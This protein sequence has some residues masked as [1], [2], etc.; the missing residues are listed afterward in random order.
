MGITTTFVDIDD[1]DAVNAAVQLRTKVEKGSSVRCFGHGSL[2]LEASDFGGHPLSVCE[3]RCYMLRHCPTPRCVWWTCPA[4]WRSHMHGCVCNVRLTWLLQGESLQ[5]RCECCSPNLSQVY[6]AMQGLTCIVDNTFASLTVSPAGWGVDVVVQSL[7]KYTSGSGDIVA[8]VED[9]LMCSLHTPPLARRWAAGWVGFRCL[10]GLV[11]HHAG[12]VCSSKAFI[13]RMM[14]LHESPCMML[15]RCEDANLSNTALVQCCTRM[16]CARGSC[17]AA[18]VRLRRACTQHC[19]PCCIAQGPTMDPRTASELSLRLPHLG[20]RVAE[21]SR[22][23]LAV[24]ERLQQVEAPCG[25]HVATWH[26][27]LAE[28]RCGNQG[29]AR[30]FASSAHELLACVEPPGGRQGTVPWSQITSS[31]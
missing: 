21:H 6:I 22:R 12:S 27:C 16:M 11:T 24:A 3:C 25:N 4:W 29:A 31:P 13:D 5:T 14:D 23:A 26:S 19:A 18:A 7:T 2:P 20:L 1:W 30:T 15:V 9:A 28:A 10:T 17:S 8:G